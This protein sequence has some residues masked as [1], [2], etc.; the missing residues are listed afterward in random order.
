MQLLCAPTRADIDQAHHRGHWLEIGLMSFRNLRYFKSKRVILWAVLAVS[1]APLHLLYNS[2]VFH[3]VAGQ[4]YTLTISTSDTF[5]A[6]RNAG[7][8]SF[9]RTSWQHLYTTKYNGGF[10]DVVLLVDQVSLGVQFYPNWTFTLGIPSMSSCYWESVVNEGDTFKGSFTTDRY[11]S[12]NISTGQI[13][14]PTLWEAKERAVFNASTF[15]ASI[16]RLSA[17]GNASRDRSS[18]N[19]EY[20]VILPYSPIQ[21]LDITEWG[22]ITLPY[23]ISFNVT[24]N[25]TIPDL[26]GLC[27]ETG[28][29]LKPNNL[30]LRVQ[31]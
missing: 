4:D 21:D 13:G 8:S 5:E 12:I 20:S 3:V 22:N 16:S 19:G 10:G 29:L 2:S 24:G 31:S 1:S 14:Q 9:S 26:V 7:W 17:L 27:P 28:W 30:P 18:T 11:F 25:D 23:S 6:D 15:A